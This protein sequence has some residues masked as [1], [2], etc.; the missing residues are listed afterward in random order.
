[1]RSNT[2]KTKL[3]TSALALLGASALMAASVAHA[4]DYLATIKQ[5][6]T[7]KVGIVVDFPPYGVTDSNNQP[8]GYDADV[9]KLL[10]KQLGVKLELSP[11]T[12]PNRIPYLLT[13]KTDVL[14]ASLAITPERE[15]QVQFSNP[16][17]AAG[18]V[19]LGPNKVSISSAEDLKNY[20]IGVPRAST[21]DMGVTKIAP[22]GTNIRRFDDDASA[23]QAMMA[24][25]VDLAGTSTAIASQA[26]KRAPGR[27]EIKYKINEQL[28]GITMRKD[29]PELLAAM[30]GFIATNV[31]NGQ[32]NQLFEKWI[33]TPLPDTVKK[34]AK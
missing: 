20:K 29:R 14:V 11:V 31:A 26:Q 19:L 30:N 9:A 12:G 25:Q 3:Y 27:F 2:L 21:T 17:S 24:G 13:D 6:G 15:K 16:Y 34:P 23:L 18:M 1:M 7:I 5:R 10:A 8:D 33:G 28:M 32:L 4:E 22:A